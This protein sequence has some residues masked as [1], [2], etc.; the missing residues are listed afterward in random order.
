MQI[1]N[2]LYKAR[3]FLQQGKIIAYPTEAVYGLG[4]D[5]FNESAV[6][7]ILAL[8]QRS[9]SKGLIV[10]IANWAQLAPL[11]GD[12][13][14]SR[15][16][17]VKKTWPGA[18]TWIFPKSK[19]IP[20]WVSGNHE[21]IAIRMSAHPIAHE[22]CIDG[23]IISTSANVSGQAPA[24]DLPSIYT[25]FPEGIDAMV[26]GALGQASAPSRIFDVV[27]GECLR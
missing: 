2:H 9:S 16:E 21:S 11:I 27:S 13:P 6:K 3:E 1:I 22:L 14:E 10:L 25:Q 18:V 20:D 17:I 4:C 26:A 15:L 7:K 23:P 8:K 12:V 19:T 24:L 5:P